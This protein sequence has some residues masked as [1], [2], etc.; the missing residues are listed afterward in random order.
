MPKTIDEFDWAQTLLGPKADWPIALTTTYDIMMNAHFAMCATWGPQ[1]TLLYN[2]A[3]IPFLAD[4]HPAALGQ[5]I[6]EVW[7]EVWNDIG[8]LIEQ[9]MSGQRVHLVDMPLKMTRKG[10][11]E[12]TF[13]TFSYSPVC[14]GD[15]VMGI[16]D[17]AF[18]TTERVLQTQAQA[19]IDAQLRDAVA[20]RTLLAHELDH[21]IKNILSIVT[22]I[23]HQTF[24]APATL[25]GATKE[26]SS[27]IRALARA[28]EI[29]TQTSWVGAP[30]EDVVR[31]TLDDRNADRIRASGPL[32]NLPAKSALALAL[33]LHE[34]A[35]NAVKYGALSVDDGLIDLTWEVV[36]DA[37]GK[38]F[39]LSWIESGGP[40]VKPPQ[41]KGFGTRLITTALSAE[42]GGSAEISYPVEGVTFTLKA[43]F[44]FGE[45][46]S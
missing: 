12:E 9:A 19:V 21:R 28:Q 22:A 7:A 38:S 15:V 35:T 11:P 5:P 20:Q 1:R 44:T 16:L 29:L 42:F 18:E 4:R 40:D 6:H 23:S 36:Q 33:A 10:Y 2:E 8:P 24:R 27:R 17:I 31:Q 34:L 26:F 46:V 25:E 41:R 14:D 43:P 32:V 3:Y 30:V 13:W 39:R 45:S 37:N